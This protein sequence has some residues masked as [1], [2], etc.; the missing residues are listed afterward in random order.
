M[1]KTL[2]PPNLPNPFD[3]N[4]NF[5]WIGICLSALLGYCYYVSL[6]FKGKA[7]DKQEYIENIVQITLKQSLDGELEGIKDSI[8][9][10]FKYRED[11]R[12]HSDNQFKEL[13]R[14]LKK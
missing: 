11:D 8:K 9:I 7:R 4:E 6:Y 13:L 2:A 3:W 5:K 10:L 12:T 1:N 14:E